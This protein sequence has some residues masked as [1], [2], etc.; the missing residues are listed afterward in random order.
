MRDLPYHPNLRHLRRQARDPQREAGY[1]LH[2]AQRAV[3]SSYGFSD[4]AELKRTIEAGATVL[5]WAGRLLGKYEFEGLR[6]RGLTPPPSAI[7]DALRHP[8]PRV[9]FECLGLLDHLAEEESVPAMIAATSDPVPRVR[10]MAVHALGC[11][12]CKLSSLC[13]DLNAVFLP[14]AENDPAWRV[15]QEAVISI[16][17][18]EATDR[19]RA[20]LRKLASADPHPTVRKQARWALGL[21]ED[22]TWSYGLRQR[23]GALAD[24]RDLSH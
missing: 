17:Q 1:P 11:Q 19:S 7:V 24:S 10:R 14:I 13:A 2:V 18:Q 23:P 15:R 3:A 12:G 16:A 6:D 9:R 8:N 5:D 22:G 4:W 20:T 21:Q